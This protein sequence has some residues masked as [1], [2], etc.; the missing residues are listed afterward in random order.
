MQGGQMMAR[1][2]ADVAAEARLA[3]FPVTFFAIG[4]GMM[5]LTLA[6][7]A[8]EAAFALGPEASRAALL[9]SLALL[10][11]VALGYLAKALLHPAAVAAEWRLPVRIAFFPAISISLLLLS[12][13]L[14]EEQ[15][16]AAR[17]VWSA[18]TALQGLLAL[19]VIGAWIGHRSF[20]QG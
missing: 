2:Q 1:A 16:E 7:R 5:G 9:V 20:Q 12:V 19:A 11:L 13:A 3:H 10:G 4:M 17:L 6:L 18:G 15:P 14:L 8:G